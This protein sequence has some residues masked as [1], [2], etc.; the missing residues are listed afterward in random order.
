MASLFGLIAATNKIAFY[1]KYHFIFIYNICR[2]LEIKV[3]QTK[4]AK[5][6]L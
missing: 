4:Y 1:N 3:Y 2:Y 6:I 5:T